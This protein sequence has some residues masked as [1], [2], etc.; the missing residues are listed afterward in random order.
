MSERGTLAKFVFILFVKQQE[1]GNF[2][3]ADVVS[4]K[5]KNTTYN[6]IVI[7]EVMN[8]TKCF[9]TLHLVSL[10]VKKIRKEEYRLRFLK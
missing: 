6:N 3:F 9:D 8:V 10:L 2:I 7:Y 4:L 5:K 1:V